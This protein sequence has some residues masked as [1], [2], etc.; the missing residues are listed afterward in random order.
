MSRARLLALVLAAVVCAHCAVDGAMA[1]VDGTGTPSCRG[2]K[3]ETRKTCW[4]N[5]I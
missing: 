5:L 1:I 2:H 3:P 4:R